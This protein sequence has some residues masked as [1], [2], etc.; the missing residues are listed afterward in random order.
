MIKQ[1]NTI[2]SLKAVSMVTIRVDGR[3]RDHFASVHGADHAF[4]A[5]M[6]RAEHIGLTPVWP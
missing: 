5:A 6:A 3:Y 4:K 2:A 1:I